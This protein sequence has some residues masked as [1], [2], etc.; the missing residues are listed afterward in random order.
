MLTGERM[1]ERSLFTNCRQKE[2][3]VRRIRLAVLLAT[4]IGATAHAS[5]A[6][7]AQTPTQRRALLLDPGP[8]RR[9]LCSA[10]LTAV[11]SK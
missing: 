2:T 5:L 1:N 11:D 8:I 9:A 6:Q 10:W 3:T 4:M 7:A